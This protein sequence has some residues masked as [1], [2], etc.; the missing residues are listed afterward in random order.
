MKK[1][2]LMT[3]LTTLISSCGNSMNI[4]GKEYECYGFF[5]KDEV[6]QEH[7]NYKFVKVNLVPG[8]LFSETIVAPLL[9]F[10][11]QSHCPTGKVGK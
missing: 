4:D 3:L 7:I 6:K 5:D 9:I 10:G 11:F 2:V 1:L 8:I